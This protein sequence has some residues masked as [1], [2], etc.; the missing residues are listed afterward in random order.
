V[1]YID[2]VQ[3]KGSWPH[4]H[5]S[6]AHGSYAHGTYYV[7]FDE[8]TVFTNGPGAGYKEYE[9]TGRRT[10][11]EEPKLRFQVHHIDL[12][13]DDKERM[14]LDPKHLPIPIVNDRRSDQFYLPLGLRIVYGSSPTRLLAH[15]LTEYSFSAFES[16]SRAKDSSSFS[17]IGISTPSILSIYLQWMPP[18]SGAKR[19]KLLTVIDWVTTSYLRMTRG[20][21]Y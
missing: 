16:S 8:P 10:E 7:Q 12:T 3:K 21:E 20:R 18:Y 1:V 2:N 11:L 15:V 5:G 4:T 13:S 17:L 9:V 6:Y 19:S 14:K